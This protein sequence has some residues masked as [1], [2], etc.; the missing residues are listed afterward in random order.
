MKTLAILKDGSQSNSPP[1]KNLGLGLVLK[2]VELPGS[3][4][5]I[6]L[7][8]YALVEFVLARVPSK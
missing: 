2:G 6:H 8:I 7:A 5:M 3:G 1:S 4:I